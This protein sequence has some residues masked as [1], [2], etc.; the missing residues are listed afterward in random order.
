MRVGG[1]RADAARDRGSRLGQ[2]EATQKGC[3]SGSDD[4]P[5]KA[6]SAPCEGKDKLL[7]KEKR[8]CETACAPRLMVQVRRTPLRAGAA[9]GF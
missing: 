6:F 8:A 9:G 5:P 3:R 2:G 7:K 1:H 4:P